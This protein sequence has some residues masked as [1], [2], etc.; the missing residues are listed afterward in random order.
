MFDNNDITMT[1]NYYEGSKTTSIDV[2]RTI[3]GEEAQYLDRVLQDFKWFLQ[4]VGFSNVETVAVLDAE[5]DVVADS[6]L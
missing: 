2:R 5:G 3:N 1:F 4:S 6:E